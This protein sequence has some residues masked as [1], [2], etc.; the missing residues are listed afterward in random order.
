ME[1]KLQ[2]SDCVAVIDDEDYPRVQWLEWSLWIDC[3]RRYVHARIPGVSGFVLMHRMI[4]PAPKGMVVD[5]IDGDGLNNRKS[6]LRHV[7][8]S[9]N[10]FNARLSKRNKTGVKGVSKTTIAGKSYWACQVTANGKSVRTKLKDFDK[11]VE[12][13][14]AKRNEMHGEFA[15]HG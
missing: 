8:P 10:A 4:H 5:H 9:Q 3:H 12:W 14:T 7:T 13:V 15:N 2:G 1:I 6:N 11:A